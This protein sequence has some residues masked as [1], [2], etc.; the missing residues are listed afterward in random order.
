MDTKFHSGR[1]FISIFHKHV[2]RSESSS[3]DP[4][5]P[6]YVLNNNTVGRIKGKRLS[7]HALLSL[8][9]ALGF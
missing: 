8:K 6:N 7:G 9:T 1:I 3:R 4:T 5:S 2:R